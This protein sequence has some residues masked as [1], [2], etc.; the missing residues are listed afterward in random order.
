MRSTACAADVAATGDAA[1]NINGGLAVSAE[2][3]VPKALWLKRY[4]PDI[5]ERSARVCEYQD[6]LVAKLSGSTVAS[7]VN[8]AVRWHWADGLTPPAALLAALG[9]ADLRQK[10]PQTSLPPGAL[11]G[12][13]LTAEAAAHCGLPVGTPVV[14]GGADAF[15]GMVGLSVLSPGGVALLTGSSHLH[16]AVT[17]RQ[18]HGL[19][20]WGS[21]AGALPPPAAG[22]QALHVLEG[23]QT[24]T[25]SVLAWFRREL[26]PAA[27]YSQLDDEAAAVPIGCDGLLCQ[28]HWQGCRTPNTD[29][30]SRGVWA[31]LTLAHRRG[32]LWR[33]LLEGVAFGTRATLA[34][35]AA[36]GAAPVELAVA[37]GAARSP[38]WLQIHADVTGMPLR[39]TA[40]GDAPSLGC[41]VLAAAAIGAHAS[42]ADAAT[43]MVRPSRTVYPDAAAHAAYQPFFDAYCRLYGDSREVVRQ[44]AAAA[45]AAAS[46]PAEAKRRPASEP[47]AA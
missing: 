11:V 28:E 7:T 35:M 20:V 13:G 32:H 38:L 46:V 43:A 31:G 42:V 10:W 24:S 6:Y 40:C 8:T 22:G 34:A 15:I 19:G 27:S 37:G 12:A 29:G 25:G 9:L 1:L 16:L 26:A 5:W 23:G 33:S 3:M 39:I 17:P 4:Q 45:E 18:L 2:W 47:S 41:A 36:A 44:T 21:Y 30:G 14:Q